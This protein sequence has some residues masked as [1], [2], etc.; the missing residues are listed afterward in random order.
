MQAC[1]ADMSP[2][3]PGLSRSTPEPLWGEPVLA[4]SQ[5]SVNLLALHRHSG[6]THTALFN[7]YDDAIKQRL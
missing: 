6:N 4:A 1:G 7:S 3:G 5:C 2:R